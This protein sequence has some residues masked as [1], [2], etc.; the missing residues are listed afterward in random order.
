MVVFFVLWK[1]LI[2]LFC[3]FEAFFVEFFV[4]LEYNVFEREW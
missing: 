2:C 1:N 4:Y 3:G